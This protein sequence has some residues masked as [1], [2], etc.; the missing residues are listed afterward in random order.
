MISPAV[1]ST[2]QYSNIF[3]GLKDKASTAVGAHLDKNI[4]AQFLIITQ[5]YVAQ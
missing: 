3:P 2:T 4:G 5:T 1:N